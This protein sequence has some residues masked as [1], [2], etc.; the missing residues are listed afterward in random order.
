MSATTPAAGRTSQGQFAKGNPG[1]PGNPFAR[2]TAALRKAISDAVSPGD[3]REMIAVFILKAKTGHLGA[4]RFLLSYAVGQPGKAV[5]PDTLDRHEL[6]VRK[7]NTASPDEVKALAEA[8]PASVACEI[9]AASEPEV[10]EQL[11]DAL[12]EGVQARLD[13][14]P[15]AEEPLPAKLAEVLEA[16]PAWQ[17]PAKPSLR[18][19][20]WR[21][22]AERLLRRLGDGRQPVP[23]P[24][25]K[26]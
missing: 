22:I 18:R 20:A 13:A 4:A 24:D 9:A 12:A 14:P 11:A 15:P 10:H 2:R 19:Q 3:I 17:R 7:A 25:S 8:C 5:D 21:G 26:R 1:G 23:P 6:E 16:C